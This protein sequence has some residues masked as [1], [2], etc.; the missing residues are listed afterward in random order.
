MWRISETWQWLSWLSLS[1]AQTLSTVS[2]C[3]THPLSFKTS[4]HRCLS[5]VITETWESTDI[6]TKSDRQTDT[7]Q[8]EN[9]ATRRSQIT[10]QHRHNCMNACRV[11]GTLNTQWYF[12]LG[13]IHLSVWQCIH[14]QHHFLYRIYLSLS[15]TLYL[16][17]ASSERLENQTS[18]KQVRVDL[19]DLKA[20]DDVICCTIIFDKRIWQGTHEQREEA[21]VC[22]I[23][24]CK[25]PLE[26][27][28]ASRFMHDAMSVS[29]HIVWNDTLAL[30]FV[31][32]FTHHLDNCQHVD[33]L[34]AL[35]LQ[36]TH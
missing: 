4:W 32:F 5:H 13:C 22:Q 24:N 18:I 31:S 17:Q 30:L 26:C 14:I 35:D 8:R 21:I 6:D 11:S 20:K 3:V 28:R 10:K 34:R 27:V 1:H 16:Y 2:V 19:D 15:L 12:S 36:G 25:N 7:A 9:L 23:P 33:L 29:Q